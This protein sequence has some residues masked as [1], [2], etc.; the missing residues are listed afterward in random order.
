[1]HT[2]RRHQEMTDRTASATATTTPTVP[3]G[4]PRVLVG[5]HTETQD[6]EVMIISSDGEAYT[7]NRGRIEVMCGNMQLP[8][9]HK[10]QNTIKLPE[11]SQVLE[12][13][14][15]F[16]YHRPNASL[17]HNLEMPLALE[18]AEAAEKY[19]VFLLVSECQ[20][21]MRRMGPIY[22]ANVLSYA[23]RFG[24]MDIIS[25][26]LVRDVRAM[27]HGTVAQVMH[28]SVLKFWDQYYAHT[29]ERLRRAVEISRAH[30]GSACSNW[31]RARGEFAEHA[32][33]DDFGELLTAAGISSVMPECRCSGC[34]RTREAV[35]TDLDKC[36]GGL[37]TLK[38]RL[39]R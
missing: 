35:R 23:T 31:P 27:Y 28:P 4:V 19:Q 14:L 26:E 24:H 17:P 12:I 8:A 2:P 13:L 6:E 9:P 10:I 1:M 36:V 16:L 34:S 18:V 3:R 25:E 29:K 22:P 30:D 5:V 32:L 38:F 15:Q 37:R 33:S 7:V 39:F 11:T 20:N 21:F